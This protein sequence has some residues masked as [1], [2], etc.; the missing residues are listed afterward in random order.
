MQKKTDWIHTAIWPLYW[1]RPPSSVSMIRTGQ[2]SCFRAT[3]QISAKYGEILYHVGSPISQ[4]ARL[5]WAD[6][7]AVKVVVEMTLT[8]DHDSWSGFL[9]FIKSQLCGIAINLINI[10]ENIRKNHNYS[11][12]VHFFELR[13]LTNEFWRVVANTIV[14]DRFAPIVEILVAC[15]N[16]ATMLIALRD[17]PEQ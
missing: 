17:Q 16:Y 3:R 11:V 14:A 1:K 2:Q 7:G 8:P 4:A 12:F 9:F 5:F 15:Q 10:R 13:L 6:L